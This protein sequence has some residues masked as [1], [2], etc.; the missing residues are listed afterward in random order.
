MSRLYQIF[1][2]CNH[3]FDMVRNRKTAFR[4]RIA[5]RETH[6]IQAAASAARAAE[7]LWSRFAPALHLPLKKDH[8]RSGGD[9]PV[10]QLIKC[11]TMQ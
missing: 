2:Q 5:L 11:Y 6:K 3:E 4:I 1:A 7:G 10:Y 9:N 8:L